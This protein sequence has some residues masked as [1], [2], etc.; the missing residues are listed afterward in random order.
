LY[1]FC[2]DADDAIDEAR[3]VA[4]ARRES[5]ALAAELAG[6]APPRPSVAELLALARAKDI[7]LR[8]ARD[9]IAGVAS[10]VGPVR[11][12]DDADLV[13]YGYHVAG[14]VGAMMLP[15]LG[16][17]DARALAPAIDLG[18]AM[19]ITNICRDVAEDA[20]RDRVYLPESRLRAAGLSAADILAGTADRA[21][22][23]SVIRDLLALADRSYA[24]A[25]RGLPDLPLRARLTVA[26]A[27]A[28]YRG[29]GDRLVQTQGA[30]PFL[31]R[32]I[33]PLRA[34][35]FYAVRAVLHVLFASR[36]QAAA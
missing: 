10:D 30:D 33:V 24:S 13:R 7:C 9:L 5:S 15:I 32:A 3:T 17:T 21:R 4:D 26:V 2:R 18:V 36:S 34:K 29:I 20:R 14:T 27:G 35:F 16:A 28:M 25:A 6:A 11:V 23:A 22:L 19:Q 12:V 8:Y 31:G 1:A